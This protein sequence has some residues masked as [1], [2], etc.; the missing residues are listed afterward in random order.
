[1]GLEKGVKIILKDARSKIVFNNMVYIMR[2][3]NIEV[4]DGGLIE[5]G[6]NVSIN[7]NSSIVSRNKIRIGNNVS[8]GPNC[9]IYDHDH[10]FSNKDQLVQQ[11]GYISKEIFIGD[12]VWIASNVYI[13]KGVKI[14]N[15][16]IIASGSVVVNDVE[17]NTVVGGVPAKFIKNRF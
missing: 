5:I 7:K 6:N 14:S 12:D 11:Q 15:G 13:G 9:C 3:G 10:D 4:Y 17:E 16:A 8:I 1:M 2:N